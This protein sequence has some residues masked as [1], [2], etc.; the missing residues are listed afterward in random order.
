MKPEVQQEYTVCR[1]CNAG[2]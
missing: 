1:F 2:V